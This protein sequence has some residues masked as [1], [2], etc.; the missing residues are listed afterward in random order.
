M[1]VQV[2]F[3]SLALPFIAGNGLAGSGPAQSGQKVEKRPNDPTTCPYCK[4]DPD[5]LKAA[6]LVSHGGF[7][8]GISDTG[9]VDGLL[10]TCDI[11]WIESK[12]FQIGFAL[13]PQKVK[14]E[15]KKKIRAELTRL[16]AVLPAVDPKVK[17]LDPWL[18]AHLYAQRSEEVWVRFQELMQVKDEDF[19]SGS[20]P[21]NRRGKYMGTGP[22]MGQKGKYEILIVP[23]EAASTS[24][25]K[26]HF[27]LLI[28]MTQR[29]NVIERD[30]LILVAHTAQGNLREDQA[31]HGHIA[32]NITVN[33]LDG[34]KHYSYDTPIWMREGLA[35]FVERE[36][37]P[38][39]NTFDSSEGAVADMTNK[40]KW[41]PEVRK[42]I[43]A[44]EAVRMAELVAM[45]D[46]ADLKLPH[47]FTTWSMID[48]LVKT[49]PNGLACLN[50]RIHGIVNAQG[51]PDGGKLLDTHR[52][53]FQE[54]LGM[55]YAEFDAAWTKWVMD[56]YASM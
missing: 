48:Y 50:D 49:N 18:R 28:R 56:N 22:Y 2:V 33:L 9:Q 29:W 14:E 52:A 7:E 12:H 47:H 5:L 42:M 15:E 53:A 20:T 37:N 13:G 34:Y 44:G 31:L 10:A 55:N 39:F 17:V 27:G 38:K 41:E 32:F 11:R 21:W 19:P 46:Y 3:L 25:L 8:F 30:T 23:S 35:H 40:E 26:G 24:F 4:N 51:I 1:W 6:G 16:Q 54:C 43:A 45:K 36:I